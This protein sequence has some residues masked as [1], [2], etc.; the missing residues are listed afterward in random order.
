MATRTEE[1][2]SAGELA[3]ETSE[4]VTLFPVSFRSSIDGDVA[5]EQRMSPRLILLVLLLLVLLLLSP[6]TVLTN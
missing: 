5:R 4:E 3:M 6:H 2:T 1:V